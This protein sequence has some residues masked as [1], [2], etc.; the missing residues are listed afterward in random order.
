MDFI[1]MR[2]ISAPPPG[3]FPGVGTGDGEGSG[4]CGRGNAAQTVPSAEGTYQ[5]AIPPEP[6]AD[7]SIISC[8]TPHKSS[9][10]ECTPYIPVRTAKGLGASTVPIR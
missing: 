8:T 1:D 3:P 6:V 4:V 9:P 10:A 5:T 7:L 2:E